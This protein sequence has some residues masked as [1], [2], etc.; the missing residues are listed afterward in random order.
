MVDMCW[1]GL[2]FVFYFDI[3]LIAFVDKVLVHLVLPRCKVD[4]VELYYRKS[5]SHLSVHVKLLLL[6]FDMNS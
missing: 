3:I 5:A 2:I 4:F 6:L 1:V